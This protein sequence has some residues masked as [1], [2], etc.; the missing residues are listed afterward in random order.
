[1]LSDYLEKQLQRDDISLEEF[2]ELCLRLLNWGVLSRN[3]SQVEQ[4]LYDRFLR[5]ESHVRDYFHMVGIQIFHDRKFS[6]LRLYPPGAQVP[7]MVETESEI[8]SGGLRER[9]RQDEVALVLILR[10]QYDKALLEGKLDD[11]GYVLESLESLNIA[12]KNLLNRSLPD[13]LTERKQLFTRMRQLRLIE[14]RQENVVDSSEAWIR[15][16]PMIVNFVSNDA[17]A[18]IDESLA[19]DESEAE[20]VS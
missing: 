7:G 14:H 10:L 4:T 20:H 5:I 18:A 12:L 13:K 8:I 16:H 9:L 1:M 2:R 19:V 3:E 15:I 17:L 6:Y 11:Q